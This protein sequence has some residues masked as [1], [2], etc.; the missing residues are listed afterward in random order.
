[1]TGSIGAQSFCSKDKQSVQFQPGSSQEAES[2]DKEALFPLRPA[3][4][5]CSLQDPTHTVTCC[6]GELYLYPSLEFDQSP[7]EAGSYNCH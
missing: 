3:K 2:Y 5:V 6:M 1:M 4:L 7:T